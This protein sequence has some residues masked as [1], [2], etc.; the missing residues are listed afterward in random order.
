MARRREDWHGRG[1]LDDS[2]DAEEA[3]RPESHR[4]DVRCDAVLEIVGPPG[5]QHA[6]T[7]A[8]KGVLRKACAQEPPGEERRGR[9]QERIDPAHPIE[10]VETA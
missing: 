2:H 1:S 9:R 4:E 8:A 7:E 6:W 3:E 5:Q 10:E